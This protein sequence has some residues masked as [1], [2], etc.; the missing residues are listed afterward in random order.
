MESETKPQP[1]AEP[2]IRVENDVDLSKRIVAL[3]AEVA[4][5]KQD[6]LKL[7]GLQKDIENLQAEIR[8]MQQQ[9]TT[10]DGGFFSW[11]FG[12]RQSVASSYRAPTSYLPPRRPTYHVTLP[13]SNLSTLNTEQARLQASFE[14][15]RSKGLVP[16]N[17]SELKV[18]DLVEYSSSVGL[19]FSTQ[20]QRSNVVIP[21][22]ANVQLVC[23]YYWP[24]RVT[25]ING[26]DYSFHYLGYGADWDYSLNRGELESTTRP[27]R[28][29]DETE[30]IVK[31]DKCEVRLLQK[32]HCGDA[33]DDKAYCWCQGKVEAI[34]DEAVHVKLQVLNDQIGYLTEVVVSKRAVR[35]L[36]KDYSAEIFECCG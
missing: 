36:D 24:V 11:L 30:S 10:N 18:G 28:F 32:T 27:L 35:K 2:W 34:E 14:E 13:P 20:F 4:S 29:T 3:E 22:G 33:D 26:S 15:F 9:S 7:E 8:A 21:P 5:L 19:N 23:T 1:T 12:R 16:L 17:L 25:A 6:K 31:G